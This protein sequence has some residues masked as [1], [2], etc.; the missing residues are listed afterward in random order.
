MNT[1]NPDLEAITRLV[2]RSLA[3]LINSEG[4]V[5]EHEPDDAE[6]QAW[7][8]LHQEVGEGLGKSAPLNY[9]RQQGA[10]TSAL[11]L[12]G[13]L[14]LPHLSET[15]Q[16][17]LHQLQGPSNQAAPTFVLWA[18]LCCLQEEDFEGLARE[19]PELEVVRTGL[20]HLQP[21]GSYTDW[22]IRPDQQW[23]D[24]MRDD[25]NWPKQL[26]A[27]EGLATPPP[28]K[29]PDLPLV[30]LLEPALRLHQDEPENWPEARQVW[31]TGGF[32]E[33]RQ[34][35]GYALAHQQGRAVYTWQLPPQDQM[36]VEMPWQACLNYLAQ[37]NAVLYWEG[38]KRQMQADP[39]LETLVH[40]WLDDAQARV[41]FGADRPADLPLG[42]GTNK[43]QQ[44]PLKPLDTQGEAEVWQHLAEQQEV[45]AHQDWQAA[46]ERYNF[47][48]PQVRQ[49]L[50]LLAANSD[51]TAQ[52]GAS[53]I[54]A[55]P[56]RL[57]DL[58]TQVTFETGLP[59]KFNHD[60]TK[61][62][63]E[64]QTLVQERK[65]KAPR[66][67]G[68]LALLLGRVDSSYEQAP[69]FLGEQC[70]L[71]VFRVNARLAAQANGPTEGQWQHLMQLARQHSALLWWQEAELLLTNQP[72]KGALSPEG[73]LKC[74]RQSDTLSVLT[75]KQ[76]N[77]NAYL[78]NKA[79]RVLQFKKMV[80]A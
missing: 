63:A 37:Q 25:R 67:R 34:S 79:D 53:F 30:Q 46:S 61:S 2:D 31:I 20:L 71:P 78:K 1:L 51:E 45:E 23:V 22:W 12:A 11:L 33:R 43:A 47:Y 28:K 26:P 48:L 65:A 72:W 69:L 18:A 55:S 44:L 73:L 59:L 75:A 64:L 57:G 66:Q 56:D 16:H 77:L 19:L 7:A 21:D 15:H 40:Q 58:A 6:L 13:L 4:Q 29:V 36:P 70:G 60:E 3:L 10:S 35:L 76:L 8:Q 54:A 38:A 24:W 27:L 62:L 14:T 74:I 42:L 49:S 50:A 5:A 39:A 41:V 52:L 17:L 32:A 9:L 68:L 80:A